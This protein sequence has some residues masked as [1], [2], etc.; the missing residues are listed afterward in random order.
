MASIPI[1]PHPTLHLQW[2]HGLCVLDCHSHII[3]RRFFIVERGQPTQKG[4]TVG[5]QPNN[6]LPP[7]SD[8]PQPLS[9][10]IFRMGSPRDHLCH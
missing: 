5:S 9:D 1:L 3:P 4:K 6:G 8:T 2:V 10:N 7:R